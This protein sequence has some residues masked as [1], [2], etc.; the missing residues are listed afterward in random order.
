MT[1]L[2]S[3]SGSGSGGGSGGSSASSPRQAATA[4][5]GP[6]LS[7]LAHAEG[8]VAAADLLARRVLGASR[9]EW[10]RAKRAAA[11]DALRGGLLV[12]VGQV[13]AGALVPGGCQREGGTCMLRYRHCTPVWEGHQLPSQ[14]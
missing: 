8:R 7:A 2:A 5:L 14:C 13:G 10:G 3:G 9:S 4:A 12:V 6:L 11:A 1:P